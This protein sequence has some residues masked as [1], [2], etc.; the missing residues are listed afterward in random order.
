MTVNATE[1]KINRNA[2]QGRR[3]PG[4]EPFVQFPADL[5]RGMEKELSKFIFQLNLLKILFSI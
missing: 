3:D 4:K 1:V 5:I 2:L